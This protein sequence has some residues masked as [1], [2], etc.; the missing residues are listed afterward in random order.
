MPRLRRLSGAELVRIFRRFGFA[1][2]SQAVGGGGGGY[3]DPPRDFSPSAP[4]HPRE[5]AAAAFLYLMIPVL[6]HQECAVRIPIR[7]PSARRKLS[8]SRSYRG[9]PSLWIQA[10]DRAVRRLKV[11][12]SALIRNS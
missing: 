8:E 1:V 3:R 4:L 2:H 12:R 6:A 7:R 10:T 11:N 5:R 9:F